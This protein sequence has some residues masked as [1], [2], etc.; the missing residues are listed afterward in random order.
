MIPHGDNDV[1]LEC[2]EVSV[3]V[4]LPPALVATVVL[5]VLLV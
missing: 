4:E 2:V 3:T 5:V 1:S